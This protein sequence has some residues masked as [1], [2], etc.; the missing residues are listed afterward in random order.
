MSYHVVPSVTHKLRTIHEM[1][2]TRCHACVGN[3]FNVTS[4]DTLEINFLT[5]RNFATTR[6]ALRHLT[7]I[8]THP[9]RTLSRQIACHGV[10]PLSCQCETCLSPIRF[11]TG[12]RKWR[13]EPRFIFSF[14]RFSFAYVCCF[15]CLS[16]LML[17]L[18]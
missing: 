2:N 4:R 13:P 14:V 16:F 18:T 5:F 3:N 17:S 7:R 1:C 11:L 12:W 15:R 6:A 8:A 9:P 10:K